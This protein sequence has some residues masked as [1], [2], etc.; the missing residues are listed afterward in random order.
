M[1]ELVSPPHEA[2]HDRVSR[3][4]TCGRGL[5]ASAVG[6]PARRCQ[7]AQALL[8]AALRQH[9]LG[10]D[11]RSPGPAQSFLAK[12]RQSTRARRASSAS[13]PPR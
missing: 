2:A 11:V 5:A 12:Q 6:S 9:S 7:E 1:N 10:E 3:A 8:S 4:E 13:P